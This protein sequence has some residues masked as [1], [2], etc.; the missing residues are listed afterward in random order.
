MGIIYQIKNDMNKKSYIGQTTKSKLSKRLSGHKCKSKTRRW[1]LIKK[2]INK[3]GAENFTFIVLEKDIQEEELDDLERH[4]IKELNTLVPI[5]YNL[6]SGGNKR[7]KMAEE[8]KRKISESEKGKK[9]SEE[10]KQK[11]SLANTGRKLS[12][13]T[14]RKMSEDRIRRRVKPPSWRGRK[15]SKK[16][17]QKMS[18][19]QKGKKATEETKKKLSESHKGQIAWNKG[20]KYSHKIKD[21]D[22]K[23]IV[24]LQEDAT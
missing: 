7:K 23:C 10:A 4:Y 24:K 8:T 13:E 1:S 9:L 19:A 2:A 22:G 18:L 20:L 12:E 14:K 15:H 17:K 11:I 3:Y 16:S 5:G 6:E 21:K